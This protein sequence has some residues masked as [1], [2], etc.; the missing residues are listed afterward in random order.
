MNF[1]LLLHD[2]SRSPVQ[3]YAG[4]ALLRLMGQG[5]IERSLGQIAPYLCQ[6]L[7][8]HME[9]TFD[10][11]LAALSR[12]GEGCRDNTDYYGLVYPV[13]LQLQRDFFSLGE[14]LTL[15]PSEWVVLCDSLNL[16]FAAQGMHFSVAQDLSYAYLR[17]AVD[18]QLLT[19][20]PHG[21]L[22]QDVRAFMPQGAGAAL[23]RKCLNEIQMWLHEHALNQVR[24][25]QGLPVVN[26]L[27]LAGCGMMPAAHALTAPPS[28]L[29]LANDALGVG[30]AQWRSLPAA[31]LPTDAKQALAQGAAYAHVY[32]VLNDMQDL[33]RHW[34]QP[35]LLAL[36]KR[37]LRQLHLYFQAGLEV[38]HV[39]IQPWQLWQFW[40]KAA[41][42]EDVG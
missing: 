21:L 4:A 24:E 15:S 22:G 9:A 10:Y 28:G 13:H 11:P 34:L 37:Q 18:P 40:R 25:A 14:A 7:D 23:W 32:A 27:W 30:L 19:M 26:S 12:L 39:Q 8:M 41:S 20:Q 35:L 6:M 3:H 2:A 36:K 5:K 38:V 16:H 1:H 33:E 31:A 17:F 42:L 29:L